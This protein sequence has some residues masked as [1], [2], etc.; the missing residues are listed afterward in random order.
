MTRCDE[1][2]I[3]VYSVKFTLRPEAVCKNSKLRS[4][5]LQ[6]ISKVT[7]VGNNNVFLVFI[8]EREG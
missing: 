4:G 7:E 1:W 5:N 6:Q 2:S 8:T 3:I